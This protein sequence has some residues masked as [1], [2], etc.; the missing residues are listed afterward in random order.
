[1]H[2]QSDE[3]DELLKSLFSN[4]LKDLAENINTKLNENSNKTK[5]QTD[6][7][8]TSLKILISEKFDEHSIE[9]TIQ[10][11]KETFDEQIQLLQNNLNQE[12]L[13]LKNKFPNE[14]YDT[15][16]LQQ[17]L[18]SEF[19]NQITTI[20]NQISDTSNLTQQEIKTLA[21]NYSHVLQVLERHT[22]HINKIATTQQ[23]QQQILGEINEFQHQQTDTLQHALNAHFQ[24]LKKTISNDTHQV[25]TKLKKQN[26]FIIFIIMSMLI[27]I[28][29]NLYFWNY[30]H[31]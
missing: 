10:D 12:T 27:S 16:L 15:H 31:L 21:T 4:Q 2:Q 28:S 25:K 30:A 7:I 24:E 22:D 5:E 1:M 14:S 19:T 6:K 11:L 9:D 18:Q 29:L 3:L 8:S 26:I 20:N 13:S 17:A 23:Q